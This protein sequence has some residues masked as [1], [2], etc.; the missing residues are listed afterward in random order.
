MKIKELCRVHKKKIVITAVAL[1][2]VLL[3]AGMAIFFLLRRG[4]GEGLPFGQN[5]FG[6]SGMTMGEGMVAAS[7]L[8]SVGITQENFEVENLTEGLLVEE[9]YVSSDAELTAG[10]K[11]LKL[12]EE[13]VTAA[14]EELNK[15]LREAEL[16]YR[17]GAIEYEQNKITIQY[18]KDMAVLKGEQAQAVYEDTISSLSNSV[19]RAQ[20]E[21]DDTNEQIA[22]YK[23]IVNGGDY[24]ETFRVGEY[25]TLYDENLELLKSRMEEWGASW[26][27]V[28]SGGGQMG[29]FQA[30]T[31]SVSGSDAGQQPSGAVSAGPA[32]DELYVLQSLYSVLE[33]NLADYEQAQADYEDA[34]ANAQLNLQTLE[35]SLSTLEGNVSDAKA[36]YE[37]QLLQATLTLEQ[38]LAAAERAESD[39]ETSLEKAESDYEAL[40]DAKEDAE[41]NLQLFEDSVGDGY[42]YALQNGTVL[43]MMVRAEQYL[44]GGSTI[45]MYTNPDEMTVT[46]SVGQTDIAKIQVGDDTYVES[47]V[48]GSFRGEVTQINP[49]SQ[50][51]SRANVTY[52]VTVKLTGKSGILPANET[53][54]VMF[55]IGGTDNEK[56]D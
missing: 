10:D 35:L 33:Q 27:Q 12:S 14:R 56:E 21:L 23:E 1:V 26:E 13:S 6:I 52:N 29:N 2:T 15:A 9:I 25:K 34:V 46:V 4:A 36:N 50:S 18:E 32:A 40:K 31:V 53:V 37:T 38:T 45:F 39:Y 20:E 5:G 54:T 51:E 3:I 16:A 8:T 48:Y 24:Y 28:T 11:I 7:G 47:E 19:E 42:Y 43:R 22:E 41:E 55:G 17:A 30:R 44:A 49:I